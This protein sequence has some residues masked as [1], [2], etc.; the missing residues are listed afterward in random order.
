M[1][2]E[3]R[4]GRV[5]EGTGLQIAQG[6]K[7]IAFGVEGMT[8][9]QYLDW[10]VGNLERFEGLRLEV[11]GANEAGRAESLVTGM[12]KAGVATWG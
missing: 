7:S 11:V 1:R 5:F 9:A 6:M 2:I 3:M 10:V 8:M 4:D 12:V